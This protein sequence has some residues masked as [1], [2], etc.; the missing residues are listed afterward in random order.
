MNIVCKKKQKKV[1]KCN[2]L[3]KQYIQQKPEDIFVF[4]KKIIFDKLYLLNIEFLLWGSVI[5][6]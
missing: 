2:F 4:Y 6:K 1:F 5:I 3:K